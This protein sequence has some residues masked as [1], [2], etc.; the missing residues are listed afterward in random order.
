[1]SA[2]RSPRAALDVLVAIGVGVAGG[3]CRFVA[4]KG[5]SNDQFIH[6]SKAQAW[7]AGDWPIRDFTDAGALLTIGSSAAAQALFGHTLLSELGL[8]IA[9]LGC[10]AAVTC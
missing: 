3:A 8:S 1:M 9:G 2:R 6:L 10:G 4:H 5:F 7:L